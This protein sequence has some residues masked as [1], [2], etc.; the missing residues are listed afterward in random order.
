MEEA[1]EIIGTSQNGLTVWYEPTNSH[2]TTHIADTPQL[3]ELVKEIL[4]DTEL[5]GDLVEFEKEMG[6]VVGETDFVINQP[7]DEIVYA[8]RL[9]RDVYTPFNK[10][11]S[12]QP[13]SGVS[14]SFARE[15]DGSY[16]LQSTWIGPLDSPPFPGDPSETAESKP[17]W[18][19]H[20]LAWGTQ[21]VQ[22]GTVTNICP[23]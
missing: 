4:Q 10:T 2:A 21:A 15:L 1:R 22:E 20:A 14:V 17:F 6:R 18:M 5:H 19:K 23:W 9:N 12:P 13:Y 16:R 8:K 7:G 3:K 11:Q